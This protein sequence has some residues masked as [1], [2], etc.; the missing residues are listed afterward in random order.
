MSIETSLQAVATL[1][2]PWTKESNIPTPDR[3]DITIDTGDLLAAVQAIMDTG[4]GYLITITALDKGVEAGQFELLY[5]FTAGAPVATLRVS[6]PRDN[7]VVDS[8]YSVIPSVSFYEREVMEMMG[9]T[10]VG[11]PDTDR[12]FLPEDWPVGVYPLRKDFKLPETT[13]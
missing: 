13:A 8:L 10:F 11:T 2:E 4:W 1:L 9:I 3:L 6:I 5:H 7:P 12:L